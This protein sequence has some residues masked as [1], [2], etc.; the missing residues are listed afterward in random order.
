MTGYIVVISCLGYAAFFL[1]VQ[2][3]QVERIVE[4]MN[5]QTLTPDQMELLKDRIVRSARQ[6]KSEM[7]GMAIF[8]SLISIIGGLYTISM[9]IKPLKKLVR[10]A[11]EK[12]TTELPEIKSNTELKQLATAI[13]LLTDNLNQTHPVEKEQ[14]QKSS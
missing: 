5:T 12:G 6:L 8:G 7:V 4:T 14:P 11:E 1:Y 2:L 3:G 13:T 10:Y 9:V